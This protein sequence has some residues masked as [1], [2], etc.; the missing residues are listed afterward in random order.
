MHNSRASSR[1]LAETGL[2]W[3][4]RL[5]TVSILGFWGFFLTA[6]LV[7]NEGVPSRPLNV[8]DYAG[9]GL[10]LT[11]LAGLGAALKW[12]RI[13]GIVAIVAV[14]LGAVLNWRVLMFPITLIPVTAILFL[15]HSALQTSQ[16]QTPAALGQ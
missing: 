4:A 14:A 2:L 1:Q 12:E 15:I 7:G 3:G 10:L 13:G 9:L 11:S 16:R 6:H 8:T 5:L